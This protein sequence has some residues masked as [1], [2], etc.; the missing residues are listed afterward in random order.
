M[1]KKI[2]APTVNLKVEEL[3]DFLDSNS[4]KVF[5]NINKKV[6][7]LTEKNHHLLNNINYLLDTMTHY[8]LKKE[9]MEEMEFKIISAKI[10]DIHKQTRYL[11]DTIKDETHHI[12]LRKQ[13]EEFEKKYEKVSKE[14]IEPIKKIE[15]HFKDL[16]SPFLTKLHELNSS[17]KEIQSILHKDTVNEYYELHLKLQELISSDPKHNE[18]DIKKLKL[19]I[20]KLS[21]RISSLNDKKHAITLT[22]S[23]KMSEKTYKDHRSISEDLNYEKEE[24]DKLFSNIIPLFKAYNSKFY[25]R[26]IDNYINSPSDAIVNDKDLKIEA[27]IKKIKDMIKKDNIKITKNKEIINEGLQAITKT[28]LQLKKNKIEK[29]EKEKQRKKLLLSKNK[30]M[31]D[32]V[33]L[34]YQIDHLSNKMNNLEREMKSYE[35]ENQL[36][37]QEELK[38][39]IEKMYEFTGKKINLID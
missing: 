2:F 28:K 11:L 29:L 37:Y 12:E 7:K 19:A 32:V 8:N 24:V 14:I 16:I 27:H 20:V 30:I 39:S 4:E 22:D 1:F 26:I 38:S 3:A 17:V 18:S 5:S 31:L 33:E 13:T 21:V 9:K 15:P 25:E 23:F 34:D 35:P 36:N 10:N 6:Q